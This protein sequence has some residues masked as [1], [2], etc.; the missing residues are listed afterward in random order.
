MFEGAINDAYLILNSKSCL[1]WQSNPCLYARGEGYYLW[2]E[3]GRRYLDFGSGIA[4]CSL[5]HCHPHL[6]KNSLQRIR[7]RPYG[8]VPIFIGFALQERLA[9]RLVDASLRTMPF[10]SNSG[11]EGD[12]RQ[13]NY[14]E[15]S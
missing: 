6:V 4:V 8:I 14:A 15:I 2:S 11:A 12:R 10:F 3:D 7:R 13:S 9:K 5:G 1:V